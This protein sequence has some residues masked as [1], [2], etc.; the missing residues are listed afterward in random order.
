MSTMGATAEGRTLP[1]SIA[2]LNS[3]LLGPVFIKFLFTGK[4]QCTVKVFQLRE[5][6]S[7]VLL[8]NLL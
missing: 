5:G 3:R 2:R 4:S 8:E 6:V 7:S 1:V